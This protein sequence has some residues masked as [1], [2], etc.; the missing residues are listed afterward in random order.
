MRRIV[1]VVLCLVGLDVSAQSVPCAGTDVFSE[2]RKARRIVADYDSLRT[3]HQRDL[4]RLD[5]L[6]ERQTG[7]EKRGAGSVAGFVAWTKELGY[8]TCTTLGSQS[9]SLNPWTLGALGHA[10]LPFGLSVE[11]ASVVAFERLELQTS[12]QEN[13]S[14]RADESMLSIRLSLFEWADVQGAWIESEAVRS[15]PGPDGEEI[16]VGAQNPESET[17]RLFLALGVPFLSL[18]S[19]V[20]WDPS[21][22]SPATISLGL[23]DFPLFSK[24]LEA[25]AL[26]EYRGDE[27]QGVLRLGVGNVLE[28]FSA[29]LGA[30]HRSVKLRH[31]ILRAE[32]GESWGWEPDE[33]AEY[34]PEQEAR[35]RFALDAGIWGQATYFNSEY[36]QESQGESHLWGFQ[37]GFW[38]SPYNDLGQP[39]GLFVWAESA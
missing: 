7:R 1:F 38:V 3:I 5:L 4:G 2:S 19:Y 8:E 30:E 32:L 17:G 18:R 36:M 15:F 27:E 34:A 26:V 6:W 24:G 16:L 10:R 31:A 29:E 28:I 22:V 37:A 13:A 33:L 12:A 21:D 11:L 23:R 20:I 9:A 25:T 39:N 14:V 35:P